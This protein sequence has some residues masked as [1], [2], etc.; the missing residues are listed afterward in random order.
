VDAET[1]ATSPVVREGASTY[2]GLEGVWADGGKAVIYIH[3]YVILYGIWPQ[4]TDRELYRGA[5]LREAGALLR[6]TVAAFVST[7][8]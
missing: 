8:R 6:W 5:N 7:L 1:G 3:D 4:R 2:R